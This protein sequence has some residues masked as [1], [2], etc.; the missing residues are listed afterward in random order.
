MRRRVLM[1]LENIKVGIAITGSFCTLRDF[2]VHIKKLSE[3]CAELTA[4]FS[5]AVNNYDTRFGSAWERKEI[6]EGITGQKPITTITEAEPIGPKQ[7]FDVLTVAPCTGNTLAKLAAGIT[8]N[9][10]TM[11]VKAH[12]RNSKPVVIGL[13]T[14]DGLG[15]NAKNLGQLLNT[16]NIYFIPFY[17]DDPVNKEKSITF[18]QEL[19]IDAIEMALEDKQL[20]PVLWRE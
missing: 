12:L 14:N 19:L 5:E 11:A 15:A 6:I 8:D 9:A 18:R 3:E 16:K 2:I 13:S 4:I 1:R 17:Q 10:V 7:L 20:Q